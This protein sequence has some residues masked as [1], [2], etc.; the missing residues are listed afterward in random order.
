MQNSY[1]Y[2]LHTKSENTLTESHALDVFKQ[3]KT[4]DKITIVLELFRAYRDLDENDVNTCKKRLIW[5]FNWW[6][7]PTDAL[8]NTL[9]TRLESG[10]IKDVKDDL[11]KITITLMHTLSPS[12]NIMHFLDT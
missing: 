12:E 2:P 8:A 5:V 9:L 7:I 3:V 11:F 10:D 6:G 1:V 4:H